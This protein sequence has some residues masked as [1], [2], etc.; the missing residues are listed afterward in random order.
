MRDARDT[1]LDISNVFK[2]VDILSANS[3]AL[4]FTISGNS[5]GDLVKASLNGSNLILK[6]GSDQFGTTKITVRA[7]DNAGAFVE[8]SFNVTVIEVNDAPVIASLIP[9]VRVLEDA[10]STNIN[11]R[12]VFNDADSSNLARNDALVYSVVG[13][14]NPDLVTAST[15]NQ[16]LKLDYTSNQNGRAQITV[17]ATDA[18]GAFVDTTFNVFVAAVNDIPKVTNAIPS[19]TI[20]QGTARTVLDVS[21]VFHDIDFDTNRLN[22]SFKI[23]ISGNT[24]PNLVNVELVGGTLTL[25]YQ[26]HQTGNAVIT[27]QGVDADGAFVETSFTVTVNQRAASILAPVSNTWKSNPWVPE[28]S[29]VDSINNIGDHARGDIKSVSVVR[30]VSGIFGESSVRNFEMKLT[31][32]NQAGAGNLVKE[33]GGKDFANFS[34]RCGIL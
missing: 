18:L 15:L 20:D 25:I 11:L 22:E 24:N 34:R 3:D 23:L 28:T 4:T 29:L 33:A 26:P 8:T 5:N 10:G 17:R 6:Y 30:D 1:I 2:D 27:V 19:V 21:N 13:N 9:D 31:E 14:T 7:T 32:N 12:N 16:S